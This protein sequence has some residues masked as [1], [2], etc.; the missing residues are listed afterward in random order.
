VALIAAVFAVTKPL[1]ERVP[2]EERFLGGVSGS[3]IFCL[4][5]SPLSGNYSSN[6]GCGTQSQIEFFRVSPVGTSCLDSGLDV[7]GQLPVL[8][9][10]D[11]V[12]SLR[13][14]ELVPQRSVQPRDHIGEPVLW[15]LQALSIQAGS[16]Q[17]VGQLHQVSGPSSSSTHIESAKPFHAS[18]NDKTV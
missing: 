5:L 10:V 6:P 1:P 14:H 4:P 17:R 16:V 11:A 18:K 7:F 15:P 8:L 13:S 3:M 9:S 12:S 2:L